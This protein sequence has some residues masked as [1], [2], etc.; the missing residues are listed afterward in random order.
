MGNCVSYN[1][2][3]QSDN[4]EAT[5]LDNSFKYI[6]KTEPPTFKEICRRQEELYAADIIERPTRNESQKA[7]KNE[8]EGIVSTY[9]QGKSDSENHNIESM[10]NESMPLDVTTNLDKVLGNIRSS[11]EHSSKSRQVTSIYTATVAELQKY[12]NNKSAIVQDPKIEAIAFAILEKY[13]K[14]KKEIVTDCDPATSTPDLEEPSS[15]VEKTDDA[16]E[17]PS[18]DLADA[19]P[20]EDTFIDPHAYLKNKKEE[21][22]EIRKGHLNSIHL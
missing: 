3:S 14:A 17:E 10:A 1:D 18:R 2:S 5:T 4:V 15:R 19:T 21:N 20:P 9:P 22:K 12:T 8:L 11:G 13:D 7:F 6:S 16:P